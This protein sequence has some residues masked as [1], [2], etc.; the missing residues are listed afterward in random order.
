[1]CP[2]RVD[3]TRTRG[4]N[5]QFS[6]S[7]VLRVKHRLRPIQHYC[8]CFDYSAIFVVLPALVESVTYRSVTEL[9]QN[10]RDRRCGRASRKGVQFSPCFSPERITVYAQVNHGE[11]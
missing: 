3:S 4:D 8:G 6:Q 9:K 5:D 2:P 1:M 7:Y 10:G 11:S